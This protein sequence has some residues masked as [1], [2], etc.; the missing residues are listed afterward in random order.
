MRSGPPLLVHAWAARPGLGPDKGAWGLGPICRSLLQSEA[1]S[2]LTEK[3]GRKGSAETFS[4]PP[5]LGHWS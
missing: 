4:T 3:E 1:L 2:L 5:L